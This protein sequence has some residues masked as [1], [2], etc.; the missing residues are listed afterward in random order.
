MKLRQLLDKKG[1]ETITVD[2]N[3]T[4]ATVF[5]ILAE[6]KI[7]AL[8]VV[9]K[10]KDVAGIISERDLVRAIAKDGERV[11][12]WP[13]ESVMTV[14]VV[15][16]TQEDTVDD[17]MSKMTLGRFRHMPVMDGNMLC[18]V[19]SIGDVVKNRIEEIERE[20]ADIRAY[21]HAT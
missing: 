11:L 15:T 1:H 4:L 6:R 2:V 17:V 9:N 20:A 3:E 14:D 8:V 18:G 10:Q 19:I 7:G 16:C 13:I 5:S 21:I 12:A